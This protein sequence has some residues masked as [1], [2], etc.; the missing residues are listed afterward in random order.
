M[1]RED[2]SLLVS[3]VKM[4]F[5]WK[6]PLL[7][8]QSLLPN[9]AFLSLK[10]RQHLNRLPF[11]VSIM[12]L[13]CQDNGI[14]FPRR[15]QNIPQKT[16]GQTWEPSGPIIPSHKHIE[17][18]PLM[19]LVFSL[20]PSTLTPLTNEVVEEKEEE[21]ED[22]LFPTPGCP[23]MSRNLQPQK[24]PSVLISWRRWMKKIFIYA[25]PRTSPHV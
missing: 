16:S 11:P 21:A 4:M 19:L 23:A 8:L 12:K 7:H 17:E 22:P 25:S 14:Q 10:I 24:I 2:L 1:N 13:S 18:G 5:T 3:G 6:I 20:I 15:N 9:Q